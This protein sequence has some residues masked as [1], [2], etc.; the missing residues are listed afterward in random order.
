M[1][2][3]VL[4]EASTFSVQR[5]GVAMTNWLDDEEMLAWRSL[6]DVENAVHAALEAELLARHSLTE[7]EYGVLVMLSEAPDHQLRMCDLA[8]ILHLSPSGLTR[9]LDRLVREGFVT[10]EPWVDDRRVTMASLSVTGLEKL[11]LAAPDHVDGVRRHFLDHLTRPQI[12][13]LGAALLSVKLG[14]TSAV[15]MSS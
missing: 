7:G 11:A 14:Q 12:R 15:G 8:S 1:Y 2:G 3:K 5:Y 13:A 6:V 9:R 10:R 4:E